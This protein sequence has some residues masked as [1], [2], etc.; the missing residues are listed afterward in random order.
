MRAVSVKSCAP[1]GGT[2]LR[3]PT[4]VLLREYF[5][6]KLICERVVTESLESPQAAT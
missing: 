3:Q 5:K 2:L 1:P 6:R 4:L